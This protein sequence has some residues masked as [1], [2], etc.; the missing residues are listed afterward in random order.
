MGGEIEVTSHLGKGTHVKVKIPL[1][2][3]DEKHVMGKALQ[4]LENKVKSL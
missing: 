1:H 3:V 4:V 2:V